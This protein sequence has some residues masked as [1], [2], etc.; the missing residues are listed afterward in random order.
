MSAANPNNDGILLLVLDME[1]W[2]FVFVSDAPSAKLLYLAKVVSVDDNTITAKMHGAL[3][4][5]A[6]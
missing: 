3:L 6:I 5:G 2:E 4:T 1:V